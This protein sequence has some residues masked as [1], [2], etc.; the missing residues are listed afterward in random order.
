V[1]GAGQRVDPA[2]R[3]A[4]KASPANT[5]GYRVLKR[6]P[7]TGRVQTAAD[8]FPE[9]AAQAKAQDFS[10]TYWYDP[11]IHTWGNIGARGMFHAFFAPFA[12]WV[13]DQLS[14]SG[15]DVRQAVKNHL[16]ASNPGDTVLDLCC[17]TGGSCAPGAT[18]VDTSNQMLV[19]A[20]LL[21]PDCQFFQGNAETFGETDSYDVVTVM[22]ATH[23]APAAGRRAILRNAA[24]VARKEVLVVD[25]DPNFTDTIAKKPDAGRTFLMG[26][27]YVLE[28]LQHMDADVRACVEERSWMLNRVTLLDEHVV[29]W[30]LKRSTGPLGLSNREPAALYDNC[31]VETLIENAGFSTW[32]YG[33]SCG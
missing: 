11:R 19:M 32:L 30:R 17:G 10:A 23:E 16:A 24:R 1:G 31:V 33:E 12:S 3:T 4:T 2:P 29:M 13:I 20:R 8:L 27:P 14:Y 6:D 26:E 7:A 25:I 22:F 28:Y 5:R 18:G 9:A 15:Y 21:R